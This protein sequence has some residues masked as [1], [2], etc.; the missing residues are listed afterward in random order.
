MKMFAAALLLSAAATAQAGVLTFYTNFAPEGGGGRTGTGSA[1][2]T[3]DD[4]SN[5]LSYSG[6]FSGLSG[7]TTVAHFHCCT[8]LPF[9]GGGGVAVAAFPPGT[10]PGIPVGVQAGAFTGSLDLDDLSSFSAG[11]V[12]ASGGT[13]AGATARFIS[14]IYSHQVYLNIHTSTFGSGEIRGFLVPEPGSAALALTALLALG[15]AGAAKRRR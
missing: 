1:T 7:N 3:F 12:A 14:N 10:L 9:T 13:T 5:V 8:P 15:A 4:V 11:F 2:V 6:V